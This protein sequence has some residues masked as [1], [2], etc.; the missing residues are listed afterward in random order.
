M[1]RP[2]ARFFVAIVFRLWVPLFYFDFLN[3]IGFEIRPRV[4]LYRSSTPLYNWNF[5]FGEDLLGI[6]MGGAL[7]LS[8]P[9][10]FKGEKMSG[11]G[12]TVAEPATR[13][14][15]STPGCWVRGVCP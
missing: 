11:K 7:G 5:L 14:Q 12:D 13:L 15:R 8:S 4:V 3:E 10:G 2:R 1:E 9:L 6:S